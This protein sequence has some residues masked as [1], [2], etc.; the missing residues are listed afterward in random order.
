MQGYTSRI[1]ALQADS[2]QT[3]WMKP[4]SLEP[5]SALTT[6]TSHAGNG[7]SVSTSIGVFPSSLHAKTIGSLV[8]G[9]LAH[10]KARKI[11]SFNARCLY[12]RPARTPFENKA[13]KTFGISI[14][15]A[16]RYL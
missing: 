3:F 12:S 13:M 9:M 1:G 16:H 4:G 10:V 11:T 6:V 5:A 8:I 15:A 2:M 14:E 7:M